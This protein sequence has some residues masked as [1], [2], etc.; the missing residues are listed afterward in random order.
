MAGILDGKAALV[1]GGGSGIGRATA[2]AMAREGPRVAVSDLSKEGIDETVALINAAGGQSIAIQGDV[3]DEADVAN[4]VA[5]TVSAFG[6]ID[7][8]FNNAGVAGRS[9]GPPGQRI[10]ELTQASVAR[11]F[12]VN[13]MGVFLCLKYEIAQMLKQGGGG[14]IVNTASIAGLVGLATSGHYVATKHGVVGLTKSAAIEYAQDGIRVNCVNPG[15]IKTPMTR[16][17]MDE[18]YDE[19]IAKVPV[20]RL[21]VP[22]EIAE[23]VV[24]MCSDKASFMTGASHVVDGGYS[25]A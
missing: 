15:Y 10:H 22:E 7:C 12:S 21:G 25:A 11:M 19:I 6:R 9:V 8:A 3:T 13:L 5:R 1:T 16:E 4:M 20:R 23:A 17:T 24:W 18:R 2:I 14:A